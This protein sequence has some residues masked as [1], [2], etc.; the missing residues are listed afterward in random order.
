MPM[1]DFQCQACGM[2]FT[3]RATIQQK[4]N[5]LLP[6][7]PQCRSHAVRQVITAGVMLSKPG[8]GAT[9]LSACGPNAKKGCCG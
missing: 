7:C 4:Q 3:L 9:P 6:E 5:G 8:G 1:Y 2:E